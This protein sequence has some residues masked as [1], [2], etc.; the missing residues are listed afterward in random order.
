MTIVHIERSADLRP[1]IFEVLTPP[2]VGDL[3]PPTLGSLEAWT[4]PDGAV[5]TG[6]REAT[7]GT[8]AR[9]IVDAEFCHFVRAHAT[10][11]AQDGRRF[12]FKA[13]DAAYFPPRTHGTWTIHRRR[14]KPTA[15]GADPARGGPPANWMLIQA[16]L[17]SR[18]MRTASVTTPSHDA[19]RGCAGG[20][21]YHQPERRSCVGCSIARSRSQLVP[22]S[23]S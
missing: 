20:M 17:R 9:A 16:P 12:E 19:A 10:F 14:A 8:F 13:G 11:V 18:D 23:S 7:P 1:S 4:A 6:T 2:P 5:E 22:I 3:P 21:L 15:S